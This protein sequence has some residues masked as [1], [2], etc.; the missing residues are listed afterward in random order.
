MSRP[1]GFLCTNAATQFQ[2]AGV[3]ALPTEHS[4]TVHH[5]ILFSEQDKIVNDQDKIINEFTQSG[6]EYHHK[7]SVPTKNYVQDLPFKL[8]E[9]RQAT[10]NGTSFKVSSCFG[11]FLRDRVTSTKIL[12]LV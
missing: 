10:H 7:F 2:Y 1:R 11:R 4:H 9:E 12:V 5:V 8:N 3:T 6:D